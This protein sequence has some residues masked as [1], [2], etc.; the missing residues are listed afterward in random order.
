MKKIAVMMLSVLLLMG[1]LSNNVFA[2][3]NTNS[4]K[5]EQVKEENKSDNE[6]QKEIDE[7]KQKNELLNLGIPSDIRLNQWY[8]NAITKLPTK[9]KYVDKEKIDLSGMEIEFIRAIKTEKGTYE[10]VSEKVSFEKLKENYRGW[11]FNLKTE[12]ADITKTQNG[13][14]Q[15]HFSF[16]LNNTEESMK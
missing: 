3:E 13:K 10:K 15:I 7:L 8:P 6:K 9:T 2:K 11:K 14:M 16:T 4:C 1:S 5:I 12:I